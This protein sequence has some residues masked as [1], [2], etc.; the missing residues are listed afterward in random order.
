MAK[1]EESRYDFRL[2]TDSTMLVSGPSKCG[3]TTFVINLIELKETIF[4]QPIQHVWWFYG[5]ENDSINRLKR[6]V[7][8]LTKGLP[9]KENLEIIERNDLL[10]IDDL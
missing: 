5:V 10:I 6:M 9:T 2:E 7:A 3:K 1:L 4:K 8:T